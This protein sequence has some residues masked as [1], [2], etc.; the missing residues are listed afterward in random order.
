MATEFYNNACDS[1]K[2]EAFFVGQQIN[3]INE[4]LQIYSCKLKRLQELVIIFKRLSQGFSFE[5]E[6]QS[7][8]A[9][10]EE[11][12]ICEIFFAGL[13]DSLERMQQLGYKKLPVTYD[14]EAIY[15]ECI[16]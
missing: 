13:E 5:K 11:G 16:Y 3:T 8:W 6:G 10:D 14:G 9:C 4:K 15:I 7:L 12:I 2:K 1:L